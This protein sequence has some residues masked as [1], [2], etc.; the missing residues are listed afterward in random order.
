[1]ENIGINKDTKSKGEN[2]DVLFFLIRFISVIKFWGVFKTDNIEPAS[3]SMWWLFCCAGGKS[4]ASAFLRS[5][6]KIK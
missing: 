6:K 4:I 1:M 3:A 2:I 5:N